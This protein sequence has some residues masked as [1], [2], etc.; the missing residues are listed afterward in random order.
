VRISVG[1]CRLFFD[2]D[3]AK[4][5]PEGPWMRERRTVLLLHPGP[6]FDHVLFKVR[7]GPWLAERAQVVYVDQRGSGRSDDG[8]PE[9]LRLERWADD[10]RDFCDTLRIER[11]VVFGLGF[12]ALVALEY[13]AR[14]PSHPAGLVLAGAVA[15]IVPER[16]IAVYERLGG[17]DAAEAGRRFYEERSDQAFADFLRVCFPLLSR[18]EL[19]S[20]VMIRADWNPEAL[21]GW[22][23]GEARSLDL[24]GRLAAVRAPSLVLAGEDDAWAP[25]DSVREVA[26]G[27]GEKAVFRSF[28]GARH[29]IFLDAPAAYEELGRF[30]HH[31]DAREGEV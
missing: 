21:M 22:M 18:S 17:A 20:E 28:P 12:G 26:D 15:R 25:L 10:V 14:H 13:A 16:S 19:A 24:R 2:V 11:P 7:L 4:L 29:S 31:L 5:V 8:R 9:E 30:L 3:G 23:T 6:G 1:D 27:L